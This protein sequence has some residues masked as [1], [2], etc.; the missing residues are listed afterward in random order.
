M[1][2]ALELEDGV[3]QAFRTALAAGV[4]IAAVGLAAAQPVRDATDQLVPA[5]AP[6]ATQNPPAPAVAPVTVPG[7]VP[8]P[9]PAPP[10]V[11][12]SRAFNAPAGMLLHQVIPTRAADFE[13][14]LD[15]VRD[16][17]AKTANTKLREQFKG[18]TFWRTVEAGPNGDALYVFLVNP[19]VPCLDY[20]LAPL[21]SEAYPDPAQLTEIWNLYTSSVRPMGTTLL[22]LVSVPVKPAT[23]PLT[24][25]TTTPPPAPFKPAPVSPPTTPPAAPTTPGD[26]APTSKPAPSAPAKP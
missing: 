22:N 7:T 8:C 26:P 10:A 12:P 2:S 25:P 19:A 3:T 13:K 1:G 14:L 11:A 24:P 9:A 5:T 20:A 4:L 17:L 15:Y 23:P 21:L 6:P 18:M 16:A